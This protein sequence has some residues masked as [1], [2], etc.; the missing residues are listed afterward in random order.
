MRFDWRHFASKSDDWWNPP[1]PD[2]FVLE[3]LEEIRRQLVEQSPKRVLEIG[4]GR[5]RAT[6]GITG[7]WLY[8]GL[9]VNS[10]LLKRARAGVGSPLILGTATDLPLRPQSCDAIVA[11]DVVMHLWDRPSFLRECRRILAPNGILIFNFLRRFSRGWRRYCLAWLRHPHQI[12]DS[13]DRRFDVAQ[14]IVVLLE[15]HGFFPEF[16]M[17]TTSVPIVVARLVR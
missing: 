11:F 16:R 9:E 15:R 17:A 14:Q 4:V 3:Q 5:G 6:P 7:N 12:W 8:F 2:S 13:R 1:E 10:M